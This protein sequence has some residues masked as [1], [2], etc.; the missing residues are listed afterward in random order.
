MVNFLFKC[1]DI[2]SY[3]LNSSI[4]EEKS[5]VVDVVA[6]VVGLLD[7]EGL[8]VISGRVEFYRQ[9]SME[10]I[11]W[12]CL[13]IFSFVLYSSIHRKK[14]STGGDVVALGLH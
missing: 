9:D 11:L 4:P 14:K 2:F 10:N 6:L 12:K 8:V 5:T 7:Y 3:V 1:L 13:S